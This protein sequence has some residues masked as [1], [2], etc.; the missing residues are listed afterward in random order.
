MGP[1]Q[2]EFVETT[3]EYDMIRL[4]EKVAPEA[5]METFLKES[6]EEVASIQPDYAFHLASELVEEPKGEGA[7]KSMELS[8]P[9]EQIQNG[10]A[11]WE[12]GG[13]D[14]QEPGQNPAAQV[15]ESILDREADLKEAWKI[16]RGSGIVIALIDTGVDVSHPDLDGHMLSGYDFVNGRESVYDAGL[17]MEQ[18][19]G[20]HIAGILA[21][22]APEAKILPLKVFENG[23]AYTSDILEAVAYA[24]EQGADIVNM[25]FG[26][27]DGNPAL[28]KAME[29]SGMFFVCAAGNHRRDLSETPVYPAAFSL[30][31]SVSVGALNQDLG[32]AYMSNYGENV[33]IAAWGRDVYSC[34]P[35][36]SYG[37]LDGT[38]IAAGYVSAAEGPV[39]GG[40]RYKRFKETPVRRRG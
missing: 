11:V 22:S 17:G 31:N 14:A 39:S 12:E 28:Q 36:G 26:S 37:F 19:H 9:S 40:V 30:E 6:G 24:K 15:Q 7:G 13:W 2:P 4:P 29:E 27:A 33:D 32:M 3:G 20:T 16:S 10:N 34:F 38:S 25:S 35:E 8:M 23:S 21:K 5:F 18:A 1:E